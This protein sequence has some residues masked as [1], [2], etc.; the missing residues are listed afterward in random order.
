MIKK[1]IFF[2]SL[3]PVASILCICNTAEIPIDTAVDTEKPVITFEGGDTVIIR[4]GDPDLVLQGAKVTASDDI[5]GD[6]TDSI[7]MPV[8]SVSQ[9]STYNVV[10]R[11]SD[12][13]GNT[14][15]RSRV[16]IVDC[17]APVISILGDNPM[18]LYVG[19]AYNEL[20]ATAI[21]DIDGNITDRVAV[22]GGPVTTAAPGT[23]TLIYTVT[24]KAGNSCSIKRIII[25]RPVGPEFDTILPE[26][27]LIGPALVEVPVGGVYIEPGWV[28]FDN[29]DGD[30]RDS[31][32][33][34]E[35]FGKPLPIVTSV[36]TTY[37]I[38]YSVTDRAGNRASVLRE[39]KIV[40][41]IIDTVKP[42]ITLEGCVKCTVM[43]GSSFLDPGATAVDNVDGILTSTIT[44][45]IKN[46]ADQVS[47]LTPLMAT[48]DYTI[49]YS[50]SDKAGNTAIPKVRDVYV[51]DAFADPGI[52]HFKTT[53]FRSGN[54]NM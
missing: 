24:D 36:P 42:V 43:L 3:A 22:I 44:K 5:C 33:I 32:K 6:L 21:D 11:V 54:Y 8:I 19:S 14:S 29:V 47:T 50:V 10:Y 52:R 41:T 23:D 7:V 53:T 17:E 40:G 30:I 51:I 46:A 2:I 31:V 12:F 49:T 20:G 38:V 4:K 37:N 18:N 26:L 13:S 27:K 39:V 35:L 34:I 45:V 15:T 16:I 48:G 9:C 28:A 1:R 25:I